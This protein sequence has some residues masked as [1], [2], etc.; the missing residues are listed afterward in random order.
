M[1]ERVVIVGA[2]VCGLTLAHHVARAGVPV[3]LIE[4][5]GQVGGLARGFQYGDFAFDIGPHRFHSPHARVMGY[6][7]QV[8]GEHVAT[9][10]RSSTVHFLGHD[11]A[12]PLHMKSVFQ[13]PPTVSLQALVDLVNK[14]RAYDPS[15]PSFENYILGKYGRTLYNLFFKDYTEKFL[16]IPAEQT[17][18]NWAKIGVERATIDDKVDAT[19]LTQIAKM[20][21]L[22]KPRELS[23]L[24]PPGGVHRFCELQRDELKRMGVEILSG[25]QPSALVAGEGKIAQVVTPRGTFDVRNLVWT[26]PI[27]ELC[28]LLGLPAPDLSYLSLLLY[29]ITLKKPQRNRT[30]WAYY[31]A[32]D[33]IFS[34]ISY[35]TEFHPGM[36][37][38]GRGSMCVE[39]T[40]RTGDERWNDPESILW[41]VKQDL[42]RMQALDHVND[43]DQVYIEH[44]DHAY[45]VYD[46]AY[47]DK[48]KVVKKQLAA[49]G[50]LVLG[51]R[52]GLFWYNNMDHS[53]ANAMQISKRILGSTV[54]QGHDE[55][56]G[57]RRVLEEM[58]RYAGGA[59][60]PLP[61]SAGAPT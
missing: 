30:Q 35:P 38:P 17:H 1:S 57:A 25:V 13:L 60:S 11:H 23:F 45:P 18:A 31:G 53:I 7:E 42:V 34:R 12:W 46:I 59:S 58:E 6:I 55:A 2:G 8:L 16:G 3:T 47:R 5:L 44:I 56:D 24:Y 27:G 43:I 29:N 22:P 52:T 49:F 37:P 9:I 51:G 40:C 33:V 50:N 26:A 14:H 32:R 28:A 15:D 36:A 19:T 21:L 41:Q 20:L 10:S 4:K 39:V 61:A 48:L 54:A